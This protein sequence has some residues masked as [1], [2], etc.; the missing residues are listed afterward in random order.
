M[1]LGDFSATEWV[2]IS[3]G[4]AT[5]IGPF[6]WYRRYRKRGGNTEDPAYCYSVWLRHICTMRKFGWHPAGAK[7]CELGP[8]NSVG[9]GIAALLSGVESYLGLDAFP[10]PLAANQKR[11]NDLIRKLAEL[12]ATKSP[13]PGPNQFPK[14]RPEL[15]KYDFPSWLFTGEGAERNISRCETLATG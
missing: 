15:E 11:T 9:T 6:N 2:A 8:G 1:K 13:I 5:H 12:Y 3:K 4:L 10:Y 7:V 14:I